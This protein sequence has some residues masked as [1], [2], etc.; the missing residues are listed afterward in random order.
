[1]IGRVQVQLYGIEK[2]G[3]CDEGETRLVDGFCDAG[4]AFEA[5]LRDRING[6]LS[7]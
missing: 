4:S 5:A 6:G 7:A 3:G 1:M 2:L